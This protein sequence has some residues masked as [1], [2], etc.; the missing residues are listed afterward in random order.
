MQQ[1][2]TNHLL[3]H[4]KVLYIEDEDFT[5][6]EL[7]RFLKRRV[8]KLYLAQNGMEGLEAFRQHGPD[9]IITDLKM[10]EMDG[11]EMVRA[12][13]RRGS[14]CP[15][16]IISALS[17]SE[18]ILNAV[19]LGIIKYMVKPLNTK[20]LVYTMEKLTVDTLKNK[21]N[22]SVINESVVMDKEHKLE[23]EKKIK[24]EIAH[25]LKSY[26][27]KGP[28]DIQVF[29]QGNHIDVKV[30]DALT[31]F[32]ANIISSNRNQGLIDYIRKV[33]YIENRE[34]LETCI[35]K[36]LG[37]KAT[38]LDIEPDSANNQDRLTFSFL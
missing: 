17:D 36:I 6:N 13:R 12:I 7:S 1:A 14:D 37:A 38:V 32:E 18:T 27:G 22:Q 26:T 25:F 11:L 23:L 24:G 34:I 29:I 20:E 10:P 28:R 8:G 2:N 15:V 30:L 21:R 3:L 5:R 9:L 31:S 4:L 35:G 19:D 33:F 16:I